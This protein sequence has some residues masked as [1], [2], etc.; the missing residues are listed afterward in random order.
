LVQQLFEKILGH[1]HARRFDQARSTIAAANENLP[2]DQQHR[3]TALSAVLEVDSGNFSKGVELIRRAIEQE[4][5]WPPH[6]YRLCV[7]LMDRE[8]WCEALDAGEELVSLSERTEDHYFLDDARFRK[9]FCLKALGRYEEIASLKRK[10]P[11]DIRVF[12]GDTLYAFS[13]LD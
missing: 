13:D 4:P 9:A 7:F 8:R 6:W 3:L 12:I 5:T 10:I 2:R 11:P 1:I